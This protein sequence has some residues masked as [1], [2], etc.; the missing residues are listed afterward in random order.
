ME[1]NS[2][3]MN[4]KAEFSVL[5]KVLQEERLREK[6]E[7]VDNASLFTSDNIEWATCKGFNIEVGKQQIEAYIKTWEI[8]PCWI[9]SIEFFRTGQE[10]GFT[11]YLYEVILMAPTSRKPISERVSVYFAA[12]ISKEEAETRPVK[13]RFIL[14]SCRVI[15][16]PG[17]NRF[18]EKWLTN[19]TETKACL[20]N[21]STS[22]FPSIPT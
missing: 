6:K 17:K 12:E 7:E 16:T 9:Y 11:I 13:V 15:H 21:I 1:R 8:R 22:S 4:E 20:A 19:I 18:N 5:I 14:E 10:D 2:C 3:E